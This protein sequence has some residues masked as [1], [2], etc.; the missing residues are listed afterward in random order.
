MGSTPGACQISANF[1]MPQVFLSRGGDSRGSLVGSSTPESDRSRGESWHC[2]LLTVVRRAHL[3]G[4]RVHS[5]EDNED[6]GRLHCPQ[7]CPCSLAVF[8]FI[9]VFAGWYRPWTQP[10]SCPGLLWPPDST[11][12][13][14]GDCPARPSRSPPPPRAHLEG[15]LLR[16]QRSFHKE[17]EESFVPPAP[18][19]GAPEGSLSRRKL[20]LN[21]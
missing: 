21:I 8:A 7:S 17:L 19:F 2:C 15:S 20:S 3:P 16:C 6:A 4:L 10:G 11:L 14:G 1:F 9:F 12:T 13:S 18:S 5:T